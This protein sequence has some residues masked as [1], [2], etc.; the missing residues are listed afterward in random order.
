ML[1]GYGR[2]VLPK[3]DP[4]ALLG[5][6]ITGRIFTTYLPNTIL[7]ATTSALLVTVIAGMSAYVYSRYRFRLRRPMLVAMLALAGV[8]ILTMLLAMTQMGNA[9]RRAFPGYDE[10]MF[11]ILDL[12]RLRVAVCD[13]G[14]E[15]LLRH[16]PARS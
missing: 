9:L 2:V 1:E 14:G 3:E 16:H 4:K 7:Y 6:Q 13:L 11:M 8:P 10:R 12:R 5:M 15:E